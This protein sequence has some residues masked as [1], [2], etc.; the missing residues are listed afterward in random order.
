MSVSVLGHLVKHQI[1]TIAQEVSKVSAQ[2]T[3]STTGAVDCVKENPIDVGAGH[4]IVIRRDVPRLWKFAVPGRVIPQC[5][6]GWI[7]SIH[8]CY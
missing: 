4:K 8:C 7:L 6:R 2:E 3:K 5:F 1:M